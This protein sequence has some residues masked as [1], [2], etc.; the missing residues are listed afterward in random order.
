MECETDRP[1]D[2]QA[3][4]VCSFCNEIHDIEEL[5]IEG[6]EPVCKACELEDT[7]DGDML[8]EAKQ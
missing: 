2:G 8:K 5:G 4:F 7:I 6:K 1:T 3:T